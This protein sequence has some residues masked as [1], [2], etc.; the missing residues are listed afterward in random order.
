MKRN[1]YPLFLALAF[2]FTQTQAQHIR[3]KMNYP[4]G[5][6]IYATGSAPFS[7]AVWIGP[8]WVW[9]GGRYD[10]VPGYWAKP[11]HRK[12]HRWIPGRWKYSRRGYVWVP[13]RWR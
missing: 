4:V 8:E 11:Q 2:T 9:R 5:I 13:G 6:N 7:G 12:Q 10:C 1:Y 3:N